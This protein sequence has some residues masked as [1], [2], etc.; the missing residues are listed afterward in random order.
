M[1]KKVSRTRFVLGTLAA[2]FLAAEP[3]MMLWQPL[4]PPGSYA[5]IATVCACI[6]A[7]LAYYMTTDVVEDA[8]EKGEDN[9][10]TA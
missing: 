8:P 7:G 4:L 10:S 6:R 9:A 2:I 1:S 3:L 5:A